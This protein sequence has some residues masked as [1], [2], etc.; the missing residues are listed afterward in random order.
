MDL[1]LRAELHVTQQISDGF[2]GVLIF[3]L[4]QFWSSRLDCSS[5]SVEELFDSFP[6]TILNLSLSLRTTGLGH[7]TSS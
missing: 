7:L 1:G 2:V 6:C 5:G 3:T 4:K